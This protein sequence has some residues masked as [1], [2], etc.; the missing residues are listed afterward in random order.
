MPDLKLVQLQD[1]RDKL[2]RKL[3]FMTEENIRLKNSLSQVLNDKFDRNLLEEV[4]K[5]QTSF[6][7]KDELIGLLRND[8]AELDKLIDVVII[9]KEKVISEIDRRL[10]YLHNNIENAER[11]FNHIKAAFNSYLLANK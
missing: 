8:I 6:I 4:E 2:K 9:E 7:K 10:K 1:E 5:F 3:A 11:Q